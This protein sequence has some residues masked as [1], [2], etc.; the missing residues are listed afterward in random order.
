MHL[1]DL[2]KYLCSNNLLEIELFKTK[3]TIRHYINLKKNLKDLEGKDA[4]ILLGTTGSGKST[5][6]NAI[7]YGSNTDRD[8]G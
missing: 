4:L 1:E 5:L 3:K 2:Q 7:I 6:A 8:I